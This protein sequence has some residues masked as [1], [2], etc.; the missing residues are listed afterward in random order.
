MTGVPGSAL[1][2]GPGAL[3][4]GSL[5]PLDLHSTVSRTLPQSGKGRVPYQWHTIPN[6]ARHSGDEPEHPSWWTQE[7]AEGRLQP[8]DRLPVSGDFC[9]QGTFDQATTTPLN[10]THTLLA[11]DIDK[12]TAAGPRHRAG[13]L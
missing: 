5:T 1:M 6:S 9:P 3:T 7:K 10:R 2:M 12:D 11:G 8:D 13:W 4:P